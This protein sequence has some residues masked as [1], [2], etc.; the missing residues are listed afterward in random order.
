MKKMIFTLI[1]LLV[2]I[3]IIAILAAML[4][5]AL[6]QAREKARSS[7]CTNNL[8]Q[9][10]TGF[11]FY[12]DDYAGFLPTGITPSNVYNWQF[13][14]WRDY[15]KSPKTYACPSDRYELTAYKTYN[16][17]TYA[18]NTYLTVDTRPS[19][20]PADASRSQVKL[21]QLP[22]AAKT[23]LLWER[24]ASAWEGNFVVG[25][26]TVASAGYPDKTIDNRVLHGIGR[27]YL[28]ADG[29]VTPDKFSANNFKITKN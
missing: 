3:A 7:S 9:L 6:N 25:Y 10:G 27:N 19:G 5:P 26:D 24:S 1:E 12:I 22:K 20:Y 28:W 4:L 8:K 2:V 13:I 16:K 17:L 14:I 23:I 15:I 18:G 11:L 29:H 21:N